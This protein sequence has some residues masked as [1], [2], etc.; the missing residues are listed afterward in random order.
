M[1]PNLPFVF[2]VVVGL[3]LLSSV[4]AGMDLEINV[5]E[6]T[7][8][9]PTTV[10]FDKLTIDSSDLMELPPVY[11]IEDIQAL[12]VLVVRGELEEIV[13]GGGLGL[14]ERK[15]VRLALLHALAGTMGK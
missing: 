10:T 13:V 3:A 8:S 6:V 7:F 4:Y 15:W 2:A 14:G 1:K 12:D 9:A 5:E 11:E